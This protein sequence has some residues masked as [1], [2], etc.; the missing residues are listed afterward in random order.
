VDNSGRA[1]GTGG[2]AA[3]TEADLAQ[4]ADVVAESEVTDGVEPWSEHARLHAARGGGTNLV[5]R[6]EDGTLAG[7]AHLDLEPDGSEPA[8]G[9]V[10]VR[11]S[12]RRRGFGTALLLGVAE[13]TRA[14]GAGR[15]RVWSHG[16]LP[17][18]VALAETFGLPEVREL[19]RLRREL[20]GSD[21]DAPLAAGLPEGL[22][23]RSFRVGAAEEAWL[24]VNARAFAAYPEQGGWTIDDLRDR[25]GTAWFDPEGFLLAEVVAEP[26]RLAGFHWTKQH[27]RGAG[28][29]PLGEVYV[30]GL[31]PAYQ[32]RGLGAVLTLAGLRYLRSRGLDEVI[33]YVD[34]ENAAALATYARLGFE[35]AMVDVMYEWPTA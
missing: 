12:L 34:G 8:T 33:L 32:G 16:R 20:S 2:V 9:E 26:G 3:A 24:Q 31:D 21:V 15:L 7:F 35:T 28:R 22:R 13:A 5:A 29:P 6:A 1:R 19:R 27:P 11:P 25:E 18:A 30:V 14:A 17:A 23:L 4:L 10:V